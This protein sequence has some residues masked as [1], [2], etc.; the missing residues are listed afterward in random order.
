MRGR[1]THLLTGLVVL[2]MASA[3]GRAQTSI[4]LQSSIGTI[5][6]T[7]VPGN[8]AAAT[9]V[10]GSL[11]SSA[12]TA[13][14]TGGAA[15][16]SGL[17]SMTGGGTVTMTDVLS[18]GSPTNTWD[19]TQTAPIVFCYSSAAACTGTVFLEANLELA[20]FNQPGTNGT[21]AGSLGVTGGTLSGSAFG[22]FA[23]IDF[24]TVEGINFSSLAD[25]SGITAWQETGVPIS[26]GQVDPTPEPATI[27]LL[28]SGFL[29]AG[30]V[31]RSRSRYKTR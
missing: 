5:S 11:C 6:F 9:I 29:A 22:S 15:G 20:T 10:L 2:A 14:G 12:C 24:A 17:Y 7:S 23:T 13:S 19:V 31:L 28:G 21:F 3:S 27:A 25:K 1:T 4:Q 8:T 16:T 30:A 18:G 26:S